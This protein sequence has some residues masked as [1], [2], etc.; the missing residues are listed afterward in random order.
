MPE[1]ETVLVTG[2]TGV[3]YDAD[4]AANSRES[5]IRPTKFD[6]WAARQKWA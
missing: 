4:I 3:G 2:A 6:E 5:G 1:K